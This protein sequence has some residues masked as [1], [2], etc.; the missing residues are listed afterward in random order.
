[1]KAIITSVLILC[2]TNGALA[3]SLNPA[4]PQ[5]KQS[6]L[7][8]ALVVSIV[9]VAG[10]F[11]IYCHYKGPPTSSPVTLVLLETPDRVTWTTNAIA[12]HV[13]LGKTIPLD[14][15]VQQRSDSTMLYR[16]Q[17]YPE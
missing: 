3:E 15:F 13:I 11:I 17:V 7:L 10:G 1:M 12:Y 2:L 6:I 14:F 4:G 8:A 16:V 9:A 5:P